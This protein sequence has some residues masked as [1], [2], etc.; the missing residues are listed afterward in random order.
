MIMSSWPRCAWP[1]FG[2]SALGETRMVSSWMRVPRWAW[3]KA[4]TAEKHRIR[5]KKAQ[6]IA[7]SRSG[8][9]GVR[10]TPP[11]PRLIEIIGLEG[12]FEIILELQSA[13][14]KIFK[15]R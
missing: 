5:A 14:G 15:T 13:A 3:A 11:P 8:N 7:D 6:K 4:V 2:V 12:I 1:S 10:G 9:G